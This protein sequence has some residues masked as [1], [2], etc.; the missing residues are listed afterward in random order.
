MHIWY[1]LGTNAGGIHL[2]AGLK[3]LVH[4]EFQEESQVCVINQ[5][6]NMEKKYCIEFK[7][8]Q[9]VAEIK[10]HGGSIADK[11]SHT[12][13]HIIASDYNSLSVVEREASKANTVCLVHVC[14]L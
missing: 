6:L 9:I 4:L 2:F 13:T 14:I 5:K 10:R 8:K 11:L 1:Q 12:T 7:Y 3:F